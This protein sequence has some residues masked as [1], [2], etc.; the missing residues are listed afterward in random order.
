MIAR[1]SRPAAIALGALAA[2]APLT[3]GLVAVARTGAT[4]TIGTS[5]LSWGGC[6][7]QDGSAAPRGSAATGGDRRCSTL[8]LPA[9][10]NRKGHQIAVSVSRRT[11]PERSR[12]RHTLRTE[13]DIP[14]WNGQDIRY[15]VVRLLPGNAFGTDDRMRRG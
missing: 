6:P 8:G 10:R 4:I 5:T 11:A 9:D 3:V 15:A 7:Q 12:P 1:S 13:F 2:L 14:D